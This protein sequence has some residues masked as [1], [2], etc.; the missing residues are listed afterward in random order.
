[1]KKDINIK[2]SKDEQEFM[3]VFERGD[4]TATPPKKKSLILKRH[5][6]YARN[7]TAKNKAIS[8][9]INDATLLRIKA[10]AVREG[11]PYQTLI[12]STLQKFFAS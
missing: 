4:Y 7:T 3:R 2:L 9:R 1:M 11:M 5:A 10:Q 12:G 8:I 6:E